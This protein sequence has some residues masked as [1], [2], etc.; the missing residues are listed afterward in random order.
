[1]SLHSFAPK[2]V[3]AEVATLLRVERFWSYV[4]TSPDL[5]ACWPWRGL[6]A[7]N[8]YGIFSDGG[9]NAGAHRVAFELA[10]GEIVDD[11][12][13]DHLCHTLDEACPGGFACM[14]RR[15]VR[16]S[17]LELVDRGENTRRGIRQITE[18]ARRRAGRVTHCPQ[19]HE[20]TPENTLVSGKKRRCRACGREQSR[21]WREQQVAREAAEG[22]PEVTP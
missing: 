5:D 8:G 17:H 22:G 13:L 16:P 7:Q 3:R 6:L 2:E 11:L 4:V 10:Y 19:G 14:H 9:Q 21:R 15:C 1:M 18:A 20:Y 12:V